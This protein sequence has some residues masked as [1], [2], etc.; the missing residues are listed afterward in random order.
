MQALAESESMSQWTDKNGRRHV[1]LMVGGKRIHRVLPEGA[2]SSDS[3][4]IEAELRG[5]LGRKQVNIPGDPPMTAA[6]A[7]Y[8]EH[9]KT[10]RSKDTSI[11]HAQRV[12]A[13][14]ELYTCSQSR[15]C[16]A[17][18]IRDMTEL[19]PSKSGELK[20][21]YAPAT[22]NRSL[23]VLKKGLSLLWESNRTPENYGLRV[24]SLK[25]SNKREF[26][27]Q[28]EQVR[29]LTDEC[30][31]EEV[32]AVIWTAL[33]TGA[34][35][36]E[37]FKI[38]RSRIGRHEIEILASHTK[39]LKSRLV[40]IVPALRPWL[41]HFPLTITVEGFKSAFERARVK[42]GMPHI[43]FHDLRH[44]C[45]SILVG[46][47]VE[48]YVISTILGHSNTQT[49]QRYTHLQIGPQ[50]DALKKLSDAVQKSR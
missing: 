17:H 12:A 22:V 27:L 31:N 35:R 29:L 2:T 48:M 38:E 39:T 21:A 43:N 11:Y 4:R 24:K 19:V 41:K 33:L 23:A 30:G 45:A 3:K 1:G 25:V 18:I 7:V 34:R 5:A 50:R 26:F 49:T 16:A 36:G 37:I 15:E 10:L 46:L 32:K 42:A 44:S 14:C 20:P 13:W 28:P 47:D 8:S 9:A 40:P 6:L